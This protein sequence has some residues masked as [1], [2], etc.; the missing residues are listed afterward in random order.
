MKGAE[1]WAVMRAGVCV[2][3]LDSVI[4]HSA[5]IPRSHI[6]LALKA[7]C[8]ACLITGENTTSEVPLSWQ[9]DAQSSGSFQSL[10]E[11]LIL[12]HSF[13]H[14]EH[15]LLTN[16]TRETGSPRLLLCLYHKIYP[17][18]LLFPP[19]VI[20]TDNEKAH[21]SKASCL[22]KSTIM[23]VLVHFWWTFYLLWGKNVRTI[24]RAS[25]CS[26]L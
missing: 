17:S 8:H 3:P 20:S 9:K 18:L 24:S 2:F 11:M 25:S 5:S 23:Q 15:L 7:S 1:P 19:S 6:V 10:V 4:V 12:W 22:G 26:H 21:R 16:H 13:T 14:M